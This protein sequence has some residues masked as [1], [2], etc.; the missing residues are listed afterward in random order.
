MVKKRKKTAKKTKKHSFRWRSTF[1]KICATSAA[2]LAAY[3]VYLD[4]VVTKQFEGKKWAIPAKVYA[5]PLELYESKKLSPH[6][7]Q[8]QLKQQGYQP[9]RTV[10]RPGTFSRNGNSFI[11]YSRGF[12]FADGAEPPRYA[13]INFTSSQVNSLIKKNGNKLPLLRLDPQLIGGIYPASY[14]DRLL[15]QV[16]QT[17]RYLI[18]GLM[19]I[20]DR[21]F[22]DHY[23]VSPTS[24]ARAMAVNFKSGSVVQGGSTLT[25]QLVKNFFLSNERTLLRKGK[26]AIMALLLEV[27][28]SKD[29]ILETYLNEVYLG[30][31]G[32]RAIHGFGLASQ[33]Y[34]AQPIQ[35]LS[36]AK[37]ALLVA[38]VKGPSFYDPRRY[39]ERALKRRNLVLDVLA[40][41]GLVPTIEIERSKK[42]P[43]G[44]VS[45]EQMRTNDFP[46]YL[47]LVKKQLKTDYNEKDLTSEGLRV[48]SN[49][50]PII[51]RQAQQSVKRT[52]SFLDKKSSHEL[53]SAMVVTSAQT[54]D[55]LALVGDRHSGFAGFNRALEARR[56]VGSLFKPAVYLTALEK[57]RHYTLTTLI[58]DNAIKVKDGKGGY[59]E[60]QNSDKKSHG[61]V[62]LYM[63][64]AKSYNQAT[65]NLGMELGVSNVLNTVKR[66]GVEQTLPTYP[67]VLLGSA[68]LTPLELA[69][70]YQ[71]IASGG[72]RMPL[73]A[74]DAVLD[75][76]GKPLKRYVLSIER[77]VDEDAMELLR[78][79]LAITMRE[80]TGKRVYQTIDKSI[81]LGGK[82]G[83]S[84]DQRDS[85][86]AGYSGN[87][88]A[89]SWVGYD[90]NRPTH[91]YGSSGALRIWSHFM[92][93]VPLKSATSLNSGKLDYEWV[94]AGKNQKS[95]SYCQGAQLFPYI[96][97]SA[98]TE[99]GGCDPKPEA[100]M[101]DRIKA[102]FQ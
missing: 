30:Q 52:L 86:F 22:Y 36:L 61:K 8:K 42:L 78:H 99:Y 28:Y 12:H 44:I 32:R 60:P 5:R 23:G 72:F 1:L 93:A 47:D 57:P 65:V 76:R 45:R 84:N 50:D 10:S 98:P 14:E 101:M 58:N 29:E 4:A 18:P 92:S 9:V 89:V 94:A 62:P 33:F 21:D 3:T 77:V 38:I 88:M 55:I 63:A 80:G 46:A 40:E 20:E 34:F 41:Q 54:G 39:P 24:I 96:N 59:W 70:M 15:I 2:L 17:P 16:N 25:Q 79:A 53:Q 85:W 102:W 91:L 11:V 87:L 13:Q 90:D 7:L 71:T 64:L 35:E 75:S 73:R 27:H 43:L 6:Q 81:K 56:P 48:F 97:G 37:T 82:S 100:S 49:L 66:L 95:H 51:Q 83:T 26:E 31:Q 67:S 69:D 19:A 74:I 68:S